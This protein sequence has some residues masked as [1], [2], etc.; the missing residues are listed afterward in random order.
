MITEQNSEMKLIEVSIS[1]ENGESSNIGYI[2]QIIERVMMKTSVVDWSYHRRFTK[3]ES[4]LVRIIYTREEDSEIISTAF[5]SANEM[6]VVEKPIGVRGFV[7]DSDPQHNRDMDAI[8][9]L[10]C[11][12]HTH[13]VCI[14]KDIMSTTIYVYDNE[15][16]EMV[17]S[18]LQSAELS[19]SAI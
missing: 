12:L 9:M 7:I 3:P 6:F 13:E 8:I 15:M 1:M 14:T 16:L 2:M 10:M 5:R 11:T 19:Y 4:I 17:E 18:I